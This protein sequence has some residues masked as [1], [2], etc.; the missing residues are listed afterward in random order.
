MGV[1]DAFLEVAKLE[2]FYDQAPESMKSL[3]TSYSLTSL[4]MGNFLSSFL[5]STVSNITKERGRGW[6]LNNL[7][8]SRLD[9]YYL[10]FALLNFFNFVFFLV[11]V[12]F[13]V[14]RAEVIHSLDVNE[15]EV[16]GMLVLT[17]SVSIP[18]IKP[19]ECSM[20]N[21][22]DCE[23]TSILQ[24]A[25]FFGALYTLAIGTGG[26]KANIST[27]GAD[28]FDETDPKEKIQKMSFFNWWMFSIFFGTLF[29]NTVLVYVQDNV[30]WGWGYGIPTLGLAISIFVFLLGTPF[31]RH[32]LPT[33]SPFMKM[34]RVIVASFR[35][36]NAPMAR[37]L[38][39]FHEL[40][41]MEYERKGTFPIQPTK[42]L[43]FLDRASLKTGIT[44]QWNLC[45]IT[46]VEETKQMLNMLPAMFATFVPSATVAQVSTLFVKQGTTLNARIAGNFSIPPA[47]LTAFVTVSILVS[48]V[49]YDR[50]FVK[51]HYFASTNGSWYDLP[52]PPHDGRMYRLKVAADHGLVHQKGVKL[53]MSIFVLLPQFMLMGI[54]DAFLEVAKLD[55]FYDQAP[56]CMKSLG[57]SYS[58]TSLGIGNFLSSFLLS[59]VSKITKKRG[60]GWILNNL[61]ESRAEVTRP[62]DVKEEEANVMRV[63]ENE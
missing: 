52:H 4:G 32:K 14:Y 53:P 39:Q 18:G 20:A 21:A 43:R 24:L 7:N 35:K 12:K 10:F 34:T 30:G 55:F 44:D 47:S 16:K 31:Y 5:L 59:T 41:S 57:A 19:P 50:V 45:T 56:E 63:E 54:A 28:Q 29:A 11:V 17:L 26:T 60:R 51:R 42:S 49:L 46:E 2:F 13:Y 48:I 33:G 36:A 9:Y 25:V 38:T 61:N 27:I 22:E 8:E 1:A 6:I 37:S 23:Q 40:P 3:G 58:L 15:E 62:V